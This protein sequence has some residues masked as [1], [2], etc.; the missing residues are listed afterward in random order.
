[1]QSLIFAT[2]NRNKAEEIKHALNERLEILTL[3]EA[4]INIDIPEPYETLEKNASEKSLVIKTLT[5]K[6]C[7]SEDTGLE[8]N[9]LDGEP[10]VRSARY[11]GD[12]RSKSNI[13]KLLAMLGNSTRR[14]ARFRT[15][16]SLQLDNK[17]FLFEGICEGSI[18]YTEVGTEGFGYDSIFIPQGSNKTF[19][20]MSMEEK[21]L[22]SHRKK[23]TEKLVFFLNNYYGKGQA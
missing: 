17:E 22:F 21:A 19:A 20:E 7:F 23:A 2:N 11:A 1:M 8:V 6:D 5:G 3:E 9:S 15:I 18:T 16:I 4:G 14:S 10:G 13:R 12:G